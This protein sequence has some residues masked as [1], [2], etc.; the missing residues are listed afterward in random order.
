MKITIEIP[1]EEI[2]KAIKDVLVRQIMSRETW[3]S[4][5]RFRKEY[6]E[7]IKELIYS[8]EI[9]AEIIEKATKEAAYE[10]RRNGMP[11]L[12]DKVMGKE[13]E[14]EKR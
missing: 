11:V 2:K 7:S 10:L 14:N 4:G 8:P 6:R 3:S 12:M 5:A 13:C 1:D 9:K